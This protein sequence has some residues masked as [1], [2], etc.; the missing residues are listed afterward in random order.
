ME[1]LLLQL[2][3]GTVFQRLGQPLA[4][5]CK[6]PRHALAAGREL[7][8]ARRAGRPDRTPRLPTP[9]RCC[10]LWHPSFSCSHAT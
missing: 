8:L 9:L 7:L 2:Q 3:G 10:K 6:V 5:L 1:F 4:S